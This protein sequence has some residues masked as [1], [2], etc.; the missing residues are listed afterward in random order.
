MLELE[1]KFALSV[2]QKAA[3]ICRR[4]QSGISLESLDKKD[5]SPVTVADFAVQALIGGL[6]AEQFPADPLVG[7]EGADQL[8]SEEAAAVRG[9]VVAEVQA[10]H[11]KNP[12]EATVL[13]WLDRGQAEGGPRGRFWV[14]DP[15]DGTKGFLRKEQYAI[16]L[17]LIEDGQVQLGVL[18]C[19]NLP[20][21]MDA[22]ADKEAGYAFVAV[23]GEGAEAAR[24]PSAGPL[25]ELKP[26]HVSPSDDPASARRCESVE[27]GHAS[28]DEMAQIAEKARMT[29]EPVRLDSQAKYAT[30]ARGES[31]AYLRLS[32][33][34]SYT[35]KIWDHAAGAVIV[36]EAGGV[37]T[38]LKGNPLD[39]SLGRKLDGNQGIIAT[40]A[41]L[42]ARVVQ[43]TAEVLGF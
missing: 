13:D 27:S 43:A 10:A 21:S 24:L 18:G 40:N 14:L 33:D 37:V 39:F 7:E 5:R 30:V 2:V 12:T 23:K 38:D 32:P 17:A 16:A 15:I 36:E 41:A 4:V 29:A 35:E 25:G 26:I 42:H 19:P 20:E 8:R 28:H 3:E 22:G 34:A 31:V 6:L 1:K 9:R 11:D